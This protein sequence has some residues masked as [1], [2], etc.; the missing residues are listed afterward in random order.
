[1]IVEWKV[2]SQNLGH[3]GAMTTLR[4]YGKVGLEE[5]GVICPRP[6]PDLRH[7]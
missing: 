4:S 3:E 5:L 1:M 2:W 6:V 7:R